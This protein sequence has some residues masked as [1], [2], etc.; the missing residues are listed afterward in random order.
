MNYSGTSILQE[1]QLDNIIKRAGSDGISSAAIVMNIGGQ[2]K[3]LLSSNLDPPYNNCLP[4]NYY[5][6]GLSR[7][8]LRRGASGEC[9]TGADI[10]AK[11]LVIVTDFAADLCE[12]VTRLAQMSNL[13]NLTLIELTHT[14]SNKQEA[15]V[16]HVFDGVFL[17][18]INY[19][20]G[21][22]VMVFSYNDINI[23]SVEFDSNS[24]SK[25]NKSGGANIV[26]GI[27][28]TSTA[29]GGEASG[30]EGDE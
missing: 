15:K 14:G 29:G 24:K 18:T 9:E 30:G 25:G 3:N 27:A 20:P 13:G 28:S 23:S 12:M 7:P 11:P 10:F 5:S 21:I 6:Y 4:I 2:E 19:E 22:A 26:K 17:T 8:S 16:T 1:D